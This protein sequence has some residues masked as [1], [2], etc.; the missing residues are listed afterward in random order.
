PFAQR[1]REAWLVAVNT[2]VPNRWF[3][4][5]RGGVDDDQLGRLARLLDRLSPG[6]RILVT[7]YPVCV[8][9]GGPEKRHHGLRDLDRLVEV[10]HRGGVCLWL[11]GHRHA[12]YHH[13]STA[14]T[15]FPVIC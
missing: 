14:W 9:G 7:H 8:A 12:A 3:W 5:A 4:D 15:T 13:P 1:V 10:A 2:S 6:P 11:H